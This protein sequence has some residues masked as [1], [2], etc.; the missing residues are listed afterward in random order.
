[1]EKS[2]HESL[3]SAKLILTVSDFSRSEIIRLF[4]Y[5]ADRIVTTK[6]ACSSDYIPRSPAE[7]LPV[8][9]KYQLAWQGYALYIGTMEPRKKYPRSAAGLSAAADGDPHALPADPR[10]VIADGKTMCCGS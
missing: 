7:C 10:A 3:D 2:L 8:L 6:L 4:N 1:M 5:P 9:Q